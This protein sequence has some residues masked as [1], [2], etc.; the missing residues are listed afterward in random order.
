[1]AVS[2]LKPLVDVVETESADVAEMQTALDGAKGELTAAQNVV[3]EKR[4]AV[5]SATSSLNTET[6]ELVAAITAVVA[7]CN[8][9]L[10]ELQ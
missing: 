2:D 1:M 10:A 8:E 4:A 6:G 9:L 3:D 5:E 7:K